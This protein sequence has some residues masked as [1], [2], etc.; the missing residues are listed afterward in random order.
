MSSLYPSQSNLVDNQL[1]DSPSADP[2]NPLNHENTVCTYHIETTW[3][4]LM[5]VAHF[6]PPDL[7]SFT[8]LQDLEVE[9]SAGTPEDTRLKPA[10]EMHQT[11]L[12]LLYDV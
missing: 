6:S 10:K 4:I 9:P 7:Y 3:K 2:V 8:H 5:F 1:V 12:K 11:H